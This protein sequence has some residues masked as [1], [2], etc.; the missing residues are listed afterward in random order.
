MSGD[1]LVI[2]DQS[3]Q[4]TVGGGRVVDPFSPR[5][6][7][8]RPQRLAWVRAMTNDEHETALAETGNA[9]L[10]GVGLQKFRQARNLTR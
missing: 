2:R 4:R 6:G 8:A 5:R 3:A 9:A 7:R 10:L 1:R